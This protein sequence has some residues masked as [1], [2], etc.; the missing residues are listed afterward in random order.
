M[1][2]DAIRLD[3]A[4]PTDFDLRATSATWQEAGKVRIDQ[5]LRIQRRYSAIVPLI[6]SRIICL[7]VKL[8]DDLLI[9]VYFCI[10]CLYT[11]MYVHICKVCVYINI[12][13]YIH[14]RMCIHRPACVYTDVYIC[15]YIYIVRF[16]IRMC[17][18]YKYTYMHVQ[19]AFI[20]IVV[21][22][23]YSLLWCLQPLAPM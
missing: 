7:G 5:D 1:T 8:F 18:T 22:A 4:A 23:T 14:I 2:Q 15:I 20:I 16:R 10:H 13:I 12:Y 19:V 11:Y 6:I 3:V 17:I 9:C 21:W